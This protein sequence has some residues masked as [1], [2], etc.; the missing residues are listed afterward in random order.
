ML[1]SAADPSL[2]C[3]AASSSFS[4]SE[5]LSRRRTPALVGD[6]GLVLDSPTTDLGR[7]FGR[8][9]TPGR[10][11][12]EADLVTVA[13]CGVASVGFGACSSRYDLIVAADTRRRVTVLESGVDVRLETADGGMLLSMDARGAVGFAFAALRRREPVSFAPFFA[14]LSESRP[15]LLMTSTSAFPARLREWRMELRVVGLDGTLELASAGMMQ[16]AEQ[17]GKRG[18]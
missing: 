12:S 15:S 17:G 1:I 5:L 10:G 11:L 13:P 16:A 4:S 2:F 6:G 3:G 14:V 7:Y 18:N 9:D 8:A